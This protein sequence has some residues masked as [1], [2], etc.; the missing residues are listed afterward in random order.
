MKAKPKIALYWCSS[1][2]GCEE[3]VI[4]LAEG[5]LDIARA[6]D[7]VFW[8][9][10]RDAR[11]ER[12]EKLADGELAAAFING[13]IR[14]DEHV[15]MA[16][17]LRRKSK[18]VLAS[19]ACAHLG[20]VVGL[21]NFGRVRD[22]LQRA[23]REAPTVDNPSGRL[24][25]QGNEQGAQGSGTAGLLDRVRTLDQVIDVDYYIPGCPP[26][27]QNMAEAVG[28]VL[29]DPRPPKGHIFAEPK[30]LC[31]SCPR[32]ATKPEAIRVNRFYRLYEKTWDPDRCFLEQGLICAGPVT[33]G[34]C[35]AQCIEAN[36]PCRGC[37]G[38]VSG[39]AD[40]GAGL[41]SLLAA[42]MDPADEA[43]LK[44]T[45]AAIPDPA[46]LYYRYSLAAATLQNRSGK[47]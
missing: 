43:Q 6:V 17:L 45:V 30:A 10:A 7:I 36:M 4:D 11:Y 14:M 19:G 37:Y 42:I 20:G 29:E 12:I 24:P 3:A 23:Y 33:R 5:L 39:M 31:H 26:A 16:R 34:G 41:I 46:G 9:L 32:R 1:C 18:A 27:P 8:P 38:P 25:C 47:L 44:Q 15:H 28:I 35:Q 2:G 22:L 21:A 13:A 40:Q